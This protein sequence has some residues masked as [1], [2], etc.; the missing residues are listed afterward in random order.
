[1]LTL[2][3]RSDSVAE[4]G[5]GA[6]R[7]GAGAAQALAAEGLHAHHRAHH[8]AVHIGVARGHAAADLLGEAVDAG[9]HA[10]GQ[11]VALAGQRLAHGVEVLRVVAADVQH[12]AEHLALQPARVRD[13]GQHRR[14]HLAVGRAGDHRAVQHHGLSL[15]TGEVVL[16]RLPRVGVDHR[17]DVGGEGGRV[18]DHQGVHGPLDPLDDQRRPCRGAGRAGAA[19]SSAGPRY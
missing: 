17:A 2:T 8:G 13:L 5:V 10:Q 9:V 18:G 7:L 11:A 6:A 3:A 4:Q 19:P 12:G 14:E 15:Q 1:M 16:K